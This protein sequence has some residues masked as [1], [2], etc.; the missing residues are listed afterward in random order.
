[1]SS[2]LSPIEGINTII[3][4]LS[5]GMK[6]NYYIELKIDG[7]N[8]KQYDV[9][10]GKINKELENEYLAK[11]N[12]ILENQDSI[13]ALGEYLEN[14]KKPDRFMKVGHINSFTGEGITSV[15]L[16]HGPKI[17]KR[18]TFKEGEYMDGFLNYL[19]DDYQK[20]VMSSRDDL[21][22]NVDI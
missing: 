12:S 21:W 19:V 1:M 13:S 17:I 7:Q 9:S 5:S 11:M 2:K 3:N 14:E 22:T 15:S 8:S 20:I 6:I 4:L 18:F 10:I 16:S